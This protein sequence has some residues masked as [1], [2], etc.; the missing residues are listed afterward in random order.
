MLV[1]DDSAFMRRLVAE[2]VA[3]TGEFEV[4]G[5]AR[6]GREALAQVRALAPDIVTMDVEMPEVDGLAALAQIMRDAPRPVVMLS[7]AVAAGGGG[8]LTLRALE[9]GAMDFVRKPSGA[10]SLDLAVVRDRLLGA[11]RTAAQMNLGGVRALADRPP[12]G[13]RAHAVSR[14]VPAFPAD[15][16]ATRVVA[17]AAA[18]GGPR[19]LADVIP[20]LPRRL[21]A[22]VL[23]VQHMP[24]GFTASLAERLAAASALAVAEARDGDALLPGRAYVAPGGWHMRVVTDGGRSRVALDS[25]PPVCGVRPAADP[26]FESVA[27]AFGAR[28]VGVVLTGMGRDGAAGLRAI[29]AA[30]GLGIVQ[31]RE[32]SVIYGMPQAALQHA[33]ADV[34]APLGDVARAIVAA[35]ASIGAPAVGAGGR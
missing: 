21:D 30:G 29:R 10:V 6:D 20:A 2:L 28:A 24:G 18:T 16:G 23:V 22:A 27:A 3:S 35:V 15:G 34:V 7:A 12:R 11:L 19:A 5:V 13:E 33:G 9:L 26:L 31:D 32:S 25:T 8:D 1:V 17:L 4:V 14:E